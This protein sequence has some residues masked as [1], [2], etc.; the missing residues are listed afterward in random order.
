MARKKQWHPV[1]AALLRPLVESHYEL[2]TNVPVGDAPR[3]ADILLLRRTRPGTLPFTGLWRD[4]TTW[5][6]LEFKGP[7]VSPRDGDLEDLVEVGLGIHRRLNEE[8]HRQQQAVL[9][10]EQVS[11]WYL[12]NR[13][14][15]RLLASWEQ[16]MGGLEQ[17]GDG[18][19]CWDV[20][21][22]W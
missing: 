10:P 11:F 20:C 2:Q 18:V 15:R 21:Y 13:L 16:R 7:T 4:L 6:V 17:R 9:G 3:A 8:R 5:N 14:G 22:S 1:F 19:W 12:A